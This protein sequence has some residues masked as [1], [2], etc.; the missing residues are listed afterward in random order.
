MQ[1]PDLIS[2]VRLW[3]LLILV[4]GQ[5]VLCGQADPIA[6]KNLTIVRTDAAIKID[7]DLSDPAWGA[8]N[9][10]S[11]FIQNKPNPGQPA[12]ETSEVYILYDDVAIYIGA[13]LYDAEPDKVLRELTQRD[14]DGNF[15]WFYVLFDTYSD[16]QNAFA[17]SVTASGVQ[18]DFRYIASG[19]DTKW[20]AVWS[21][22]VEVVENGWVVE[23]KIPFSMLRFPDAKEQNW[24]INFGRSIMKNGE[25]VYW[26]HI[27]PDLEGEVIQS[28]ELHGLNNIK[29]SVRFM[30]TPYLISYLDEYHDPSTNTPAKWGSSINGGLDLKLGLNEAFTLDA[31]LIPDFGQVQ[32]DDLVLNL[33]PFEIRFDENRQFFTEGIELFD[34]AGLFYSRRIGST[35]FYFHDVGRELQPGERIIDNPAQSPLI[36][37]MK[38]TGRTRGGTGLGFFNAIEGKTRATILKEDGTERTVVTNPLT[39]YNLFV[40]D[41][42]LPNSS[43]VTFTNTNVMRSGAA[44]DANVTSVNFNLRNPSQTYAVG[45]S[46]V[47]NLKNSPEAYTGGHAYRF[48]FSKIAGAFTYNAIYNVESL[49]YDIN[50]L[51]FNNSPNRRHLSLRTNYRWF[52]P[53]GPF[54][55]A[56][57]SMWTFYLRMHEPNVY[58]EHGTLV[59]NWFTLRNQVSFGWFSYF[60]FIKSHDYFEPRTPDFSLYFLE[61]RNLNI[62][63]FLNSDPRKAFRYGG[64]ASYR[65]YYTPGRDRYEGSF[66]ITYQANDRLTTSWNSNTYSGNRDI[67][68]V[69]RHEQDVILGVRDQNIVENSLNLK[70]AFNNKIATNMRLRHYWTK[71]AYEDFGAL[72]TDGNLGETSYPGFNGDGGSKHDFTVDFF[73]IDLRLIWRYAPGSD[74]ILVWKQSISNI[75]QRAIGSYFNNLGNLGTFP[76]SNNISLRINYFLDYATVVKQIKS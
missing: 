48:N 32:A 69:A 61:P 36:N 64:R 33:S 26:N 43:F 22:A 72:G 13:M 40:V 56:T 30:L 62:G 21:S 39:N 55:N 17:F 57:V 28:G 54:Q 9:I 70:Y 47:Y 34:K 15:D 42:N 41:Q 11:G 67:G 52:E 24:R 14:G 25:E 73:N 49:D 7:G 63:G 53:F 37:A 35:P 10:A 12:T 3:A 6:R 45:G 2:L 38:V 68:F 19:I 46:T 5:S 44:Y 4:A 71:V 27:R 29:R 18:G 66:F 76:Q 50:D 1:L 59:E 31:I 58:S 51:G 75:D 16:G 74:I 60:E 23:M 8:S 20:D 65:K